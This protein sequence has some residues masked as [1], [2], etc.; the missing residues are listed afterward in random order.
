MTFTLTREQFEQKKQELAISQ[1]IVV[2]GDS[3]TLSHSGVT[4]MYSYNQPTSTLTIAITSR[5]FLISRA[6]VESRIR[7]WFDGTGT[8]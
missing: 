2:I 3:S 7:Q 6:A 5:P 4:V 8:V 1:G